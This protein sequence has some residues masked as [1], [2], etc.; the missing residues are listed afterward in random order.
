[1]VLRRDNDGWP[2]LLVIGTSDGV[3]PLTRLYR[4][5]RDGSFADAK[6]ELPN[7]VGGSVAWADYNLDGTLDLVLT[8]FDGV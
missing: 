2:D 5:C 8:G 3:T 1:M 6:A 4:N 7:L